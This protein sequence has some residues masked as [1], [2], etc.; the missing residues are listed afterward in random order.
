MDDMLELEGSKIP[1][2]QLNACQYKDIAMNSP[3]WNASALD[4]YV[5]IS[6]P[7]NL[8]SHASLY[9]VAEVSP[10]GLK[11]VPKEAI[12]RDV[13]CWLKGTV[14]ML[15]LGVGLH[16]YKLMFADTLTSTVFDLYIG[17]NIQ[18]DNPDKPYVY[19]KREESSC[20]GSGCDI[21][22]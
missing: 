3:M 11:Y 10:E 21:S 20:D 16:I 19:M 18:N 7:H 9:D 14:S 22:G 13:N 6:V 1:A 8:L 17:Y 4:Y 15:N 5:Y 12:V 2:L